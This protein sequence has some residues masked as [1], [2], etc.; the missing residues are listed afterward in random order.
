MS[1]PVFM[2]ADVSHSDGKVY[3]VFYRIEAGKIVVLAI[4]DT[5]YA[6]LEGKSDE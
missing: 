3:R 4:H 6:P 5:A 1:E 2:A